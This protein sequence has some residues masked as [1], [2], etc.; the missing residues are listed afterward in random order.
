[1]I[2]QLINDYWMILIAQKRFFQAP[3]FTARCLAAN[4]WGEPGSG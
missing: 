1:M 2:D 3:G 4:P